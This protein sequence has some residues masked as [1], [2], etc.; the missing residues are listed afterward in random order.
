MKCI[1]DI[2]HESNSFTRILKVSNQLN[3]IINQ[4]S[5]EGL[6]ENTAKFGQG[7]TSVIATRVRHGF[8][9]FVQANDDCF[10]RLR[11]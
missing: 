8:L 11:F 2:I 5:L 9:Y 4:S 10:S 3:Q 1:G 7:V 6:H